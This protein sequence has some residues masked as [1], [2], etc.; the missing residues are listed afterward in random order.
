ML[1][2]KSLEAFFNKK[3]TPVDRENLPI[4]REDLP[5]VP[6][7]S[8]AQLEKIENRTHSMV[9][10]PVKEVI[11]DREKQYLR[12]ITSETYINGYDISIFIHKIS[13]DKAKKIKR[14]IDDYKK[15]GEICVHLSV[16]RR[17]N[18]SPRRREFPYNLDIWYGEDHRA[19]Y[20]IDI[21]KIY[22]LRDDIRNP[23]LRT[24][25]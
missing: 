7:T 3:N 6:V 19:D 21:G 17:L 10:L 16:E 24:V 9:C 22:A 13:Y 14:I 2:D 1:T 15:S 4:E 8:R 5:R 20:L 25:S 23:I 12:L 18:D 11:I